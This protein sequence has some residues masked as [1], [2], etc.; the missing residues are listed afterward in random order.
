MRTNLNSRSASI[1]LRTSILVGL[2]SSSAAFAD[3]LLGLYAGGAVGES[4]VE[5]DSGGFSSGSFKANHSAFKAMLGIRPISLVGAELDYV[6]FGHPDGAFA[7]RS[8]NVDMKGAAGF[9]VLYLPVPVIDVFLKLGLARVQSTAAGQAIPPFCPANLPC[10][11]SLF[12][13]DR[14]DTHVAEGVGVQ[15]KLGPV[16]ARGEYERFDA[17]GAN[18]S[19]WSLGLTYSF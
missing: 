11:P 9:G 3:G 7:N 16:A 15:Y 6:D 12:R 10:S 4:S 13:L 18:P 1:L 8:G 14:T 17:A 2:L 5:A 19:L